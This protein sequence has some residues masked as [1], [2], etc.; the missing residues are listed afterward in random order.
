MNPL[1]WTNAMKATVIGLANSTIALAVAFGA[2][3]TDT[4]SAAILAWVNALLV[5]FVAATYRNSPTRIPDTSSTT[6]S[7]TSEITTP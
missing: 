1:D 7:T 5:A 3:I 4:Q 2:P 6:S